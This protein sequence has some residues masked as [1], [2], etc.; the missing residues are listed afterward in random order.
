MKR[1]IKPF[2][3]FARRAKRL[4]KKFQSLEDDLKALVLRLTEDPRQGESLGGGLYKI[5][6]GS[7]SKGGGFRIVTYYVEQTTEGEVVY[8]VTIYDKSEEANIL[9]TDLLNTIKQEL[10]Q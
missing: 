6:L 3:E 8:L 7:A 4:K 5:R 1:M 9:K 2:R 10:E